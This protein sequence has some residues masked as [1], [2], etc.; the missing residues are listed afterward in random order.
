MRKNHRDECETCKLLAKC[1]VTGKASPI[2]APQGCRKL[3][4]LQAFNEILKQGNDNNGKTGL[5]HFNLS[6]KKKGKKNH[7]RHKGPTRQIDI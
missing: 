7:E 2:M 3:S 4:A 1:A 5:S 6:S